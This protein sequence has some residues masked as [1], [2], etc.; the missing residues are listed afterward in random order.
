MAQ[1]RIRP[2]S[3]CFRNRFRFPSG[4]GSNH[5]HHFPFLNLAVQPCS[6]RKSIP[7]FIQRFGISG[8]D[9]PINLLLQAKRTE[10]NWPIPKLSVAETCIRRV[11]SNN[12][13]GGMLHICFPGKQRTPIYLYPCF[14]LPMLFHFSCAQI[15]SEPEITE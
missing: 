6:S 12:T 14:C 3:S 9:A 7:R 10:I 4:S 8:F 15:I 5:S 11:N 1:V 2:L 13:G